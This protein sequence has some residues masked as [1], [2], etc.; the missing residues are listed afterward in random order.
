MM[1]FDL[2][3]Y[4]YNFWH[5]FLITSYL[6]TEIQKYIN[7]MSTKK[8]PSR[9]LSPSREL[10]CRE[11]LF[12][13]E[14]QEEFQEPETWTV[15]T[16]LDRILE[17]ARGSKLSHS[18]WESARSPLDFL[19]DKLE[20]TNVQIVVLAIMV[21]KG[22]AIS[23][24]GIANH[25]CCS[26]LSLMAYSDEIEDLVKKRWA[27]RRYVHELAGYYQG[28]KLVFG[29]IKALRNNQAY[30]PEKIDGLNEQQFIDKL[31]SHLD[32]NFN[33][34]D[35]VFCDDEEWML[36]FVNSNPDL[37]LCREVL[38]Y[39]NIHVQSLL[40]LERRLVLRRKVII[41]HKHPAARARGNDPGQPVV[42]R[43]RGEYEGAAMQQQHRG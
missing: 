38:S 36:T 42:V 29:V 9:T 24:K 20:L 35:A 13:Q 34:R 25:L 31:E 1:S 43:Q 14:E 23:W 21:E 40:L 33:D 3:C 22:E 32:K 11:T 19:R 2:A 8:Q 39:D 16:A 12:N 26:R 41:R 27:M 28:F 4:R 17:Q 7:I 15:I 18:F 37:P 10:K 30:V 6:C 5:F